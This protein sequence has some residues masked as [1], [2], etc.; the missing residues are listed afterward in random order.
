MLPNKNI[1]LQP[2]HTFAST[3][4]AQ[5]FIS[6]DRKEQIEEVVTWAKA[7]M[8]PLLILGAGSNVLFT[9][10]FEGVVAKMEI[11]GIKK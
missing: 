7:Q 11:M 9:K 5:F 8:L 4:K 6:I 3:E 2:Y 1:S 10:N